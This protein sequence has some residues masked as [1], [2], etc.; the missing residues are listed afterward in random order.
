MATA[1]AMVAASAAMATAAAMVAA[2]AAMAAAVADKLYIRQR[3]S[4]GFLV[5]DI[6]RRQADVGDFLLTESYVVTISGVPHWDICRPPG[7]C[8]CDTRQ[9][10]RQSGGPQ[11]R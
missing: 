2:M 11:H 7:C 4:V 8:G 10:Q 6:E 9:R 5:E 1:A 3:C